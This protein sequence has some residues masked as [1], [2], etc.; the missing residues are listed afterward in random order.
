LIRTGDPR[1]MDVVAI[2]LAL[3]TFA[4]L[5]GSIELFDRV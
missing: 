2:V 3:V 5:L 1:R 4:A